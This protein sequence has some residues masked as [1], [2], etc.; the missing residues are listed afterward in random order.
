MFI[1]PACYILDLLAV[2]CIFTGRF[3]FSS[4]GLHTTLEG[5]A[6]ILGRIERFPI[7]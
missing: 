2:S 7:R 1:L 3:T 5:Y 4:M 6:N